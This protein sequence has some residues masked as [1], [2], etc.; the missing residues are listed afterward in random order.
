ME[1][2]VAVFITTRKFGL[3]HLDR[4]RE[5]NAN[6]PIHCVVAEENPIPEKG[7]INCDRNIRDWWISIGRHLK[8][9]HAVFIE[10]DVLF[11]SPVGE[12]F[13][14]DSH[15][16]GKDVKKPGMPWNWFS[17][18]PFLPEEMKPHATGVAPFAVVRISRVCLADMFSHPL[19]EPLYGRDIFSELRLPTL[20]VAC[21]Y[22]PENHHGKLDNVHFNP[23]TPE[24]GI[25]VWHC[26]KERVE[27][28]SK[29]E[30]KP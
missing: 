1:N 13:Q 26:V 2:I 14:G 23:I 12:I 29:M 22:E 8:F 10:G 20:A 19:V 24:S 9:R 30:V 15:F 25:G 3:P 18:I 27:P 17:Q 21:G 11:S 28:S 16:M 7:W 4:F 5:H 6:I